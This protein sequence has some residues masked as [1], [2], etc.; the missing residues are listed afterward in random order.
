MTAF[1]VFY[2]LREAREKEEPAISP[3]H[4][5]R[6][7]NRTKFPNREWAVPW[8]KACLAVESSASKT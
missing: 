5:K 3:F 2:V 4:G 7:S 6:K 8:Q 1:Y